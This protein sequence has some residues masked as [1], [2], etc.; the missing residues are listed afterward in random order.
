MNGQFDAELSA[1]LL[2]ASLAWGRGEIYYLSE[3]RKIMAVFRVEHD[4]ELLPFSFH[5][6][7][8][9]ALRITDEIAENIIEVIVLVAAALGF[10]DLKQ[11]RSV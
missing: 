7:V 5:R 8:C 2:G 3:D 11:G 9:A 10:G 1:A 4:L 6:H